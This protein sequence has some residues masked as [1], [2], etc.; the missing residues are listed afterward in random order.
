MSAP[1]LRPASN[2]ISHA[3]SGLQLD[4]CEHLRKDT[5]WVEQQLLLPSTAVMLFDRESIL[6]AP[7]RTTCLLPLQEVRALVPDVSEEI[8][9]LGL[10]ST[11]GISSTSAAAPPH[12]ITAKRI[13]KGDAE[14]HQATFSSQGWEWMGIRNYLM[15]SAVDAPDVAAVVGLG[16]SMTHWHATA[17]YC[18]QC[19]AKTAVSEGGMSR[20]CTGGCKEKD[21]PRINPCAIMLVLDGEGRCLLG[22]GKGRP[23]HTTLAGFMSHGESVEETVVREVFEESGVGVSNVYYHS[24]QPWPFPCQLMLGFHA[25]AD[26]QR[27][28]I[29]ADPHEMD[30]VQ[31]MAKEDVRLAL[32]GLHPTFTVPPPLSISH[33]LIKAWVDGVV[34]DFGAPQVSRGGVA[35]SSL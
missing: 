20:A 21:Y 11:N 13:G 33:Q 15:T 29:V 10:T 6:H 12:A 16:K 35:Q 23:F 27:R 9:F 25:Y 8:I 18:A 28:T 14:K 22:K 3:L 17:R 31:W 26:P 7:A 24:S 4:R 19:G 2:I 5:A 1:I 34:D 30:D 32:Q